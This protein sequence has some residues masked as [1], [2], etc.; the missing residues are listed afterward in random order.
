MASMRHEDS[1]DNDDILNPMTPWRSAALIF[2]S[3]WGAVLLG[4][5]LP[6]SY[7]GFRPWH[8]LLPFLAVAGYWALWMAWRIAQRR[9]QYLSRERRVALGRDRP[10]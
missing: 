4:P 5:F 2:V 1:D 8:L 6:G 10:H 3:A 9:Q 7:A